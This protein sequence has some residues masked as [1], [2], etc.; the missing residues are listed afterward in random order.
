[1]KVCPTC[2]G[3]GYVKSGLYRPSPTGV[4]PITEPCRE[5]ESSGEV[6]SEGEAA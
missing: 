1:M 6:E 2:H 4:E 3:N 5:C